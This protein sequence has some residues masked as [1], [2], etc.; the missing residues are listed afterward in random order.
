[1][2][3]VGL[4][5]LPAFLVWGKGGGRASDSMPMTNAEKVMWALVPLAAVAAAVAFWV[6][7][8]QDKIELG[9]GYSLSARP[10]VLF[11]AL[12]VLVVLYVLDRFYYYKL[13]MGAVG[14]AAELE[15]ALGFRMTKTITNFVLP[16]HAA[17]T[18]TLLYFVPGMAAFCLLLVLLGF[19]PLITQS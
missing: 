18:I 4:L 15:E 1:M 10:I 14:R 17:T 2:S 8:W 19:N 9:L 11:F 3:A 7:R 16:Q 13:L 6:L 5:V 12:A